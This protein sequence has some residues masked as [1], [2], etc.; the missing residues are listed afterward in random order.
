MS[1]PRP[2]P[3][4]AVEPGTEIGT[5]VVV[6]DRAVS[7]RTRRF[8]ADGFVQRNLVDK[9]RIG[10]QSPYV[11]LRIPSSPVPTKRTQTINRGGQAPEWDAELRFPIMSEL[12][13]TLG[14]KNNNGKSMTV[15]CWADD[16]REPTKVGEAFVDLTRSLTKGEDDCE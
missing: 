7:F 6:V 11:T 10:K 1:P 2:P 4:A 8:I 14:V 9:Q 16:S 15:V 13:D 5:L 12:E 3:K